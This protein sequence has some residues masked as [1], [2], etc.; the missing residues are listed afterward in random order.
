[1]DGIPFQLAGVIRFCAVTPG[2]PNDRLPDVRDGQRRFL[3][4]ISLHN[5]VR[6]AVD[7]GVAWLDKNQDTNGFWSTADYPAITALGLMAHQP[8][9]CPREAGHR[10]RADCAADDLP[11]DLI[12][13]RGTRY[14]KET[15]GI[16]I[17][18]LVKR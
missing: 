7:K 15:L 8:Q 12:M 17:V 9:L 2:T 6:R 1:M 10:V 16:V 4:D 18:K 13:S 11:Q 3:P 14:D 5:E